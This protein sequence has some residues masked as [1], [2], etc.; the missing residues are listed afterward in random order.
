MSKIQPLHKNKNFSRSRID[1]RGKPFNYLSSPHYTLATSQSKFR[2]Y[3]QRKLSSNGTN[4]VVL[5]Q[6]V[7]DLVFF[8][9]ASPLNLEIIGF[10][11]LGLVDR[12]MRALIIY[13]QHYLVTWQEL[14]AKRAATAKRAAN[15][16]AGGAR[17]ER[18]EEMRALRLLLAREYADLLKG[19]EKEAKRY[20]HAGAGE[21]THAQSR[22]EK[23]I[24]MFEGVIQ[25]AHR[26][27]W[28][29]LERKHKELM[30]IISASIYDTETN[31]I[32]P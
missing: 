24:R 23:D 11:H 26:V 19:C 18:A 32:F 20:H 29:T 8:L 27:A 5:L 7:K 28:I 31:L 12:F 15:P 2:K 16:L 10:L 25:F 1:D 22:P 21:M 6:D 17:V 13:L 4:D 30:G 9:L 3:Y 14:G